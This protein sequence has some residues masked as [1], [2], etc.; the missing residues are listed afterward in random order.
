MKKKL[1]ILMAIVMTLAV[2]APFGTANLMAAGAPGLATGVSFFDFGQTN[3]NRTRGINAAFGANTVFVDRSLTGIPFG[4]MHN[5]VNVWQGNNDART[6]LQMQRALEGVAADMRV[7]LI[8]HIPTALPAIRDFA[9][10]VTGAQFVYAQNALVNS[11]GTAITTGGAGAGAANFNTDLFT[12]GDLGPARLG[13]NTG[14]RFGTITPTAAYFEAAAFNNLQTRVSLGAAQRIGYTMTIQNANTVSVSLGNNE[15]G[16]AVAENAYIVIPVVLRPTGTDT[17]RISWGGGNVSFDALTINNAAA[18]ILAGTNVSDVTLASAGRGHIVLPDLIVNE[19]APNALQNGWAFITPP[20]G[21]NLNSANAAI[22][23]NRANSWVFRFGASN[24]V[25]AQ[26]SFTFRDA[27]NPDPAAPRT[28]FAFQFS[29][30]TAPRLGIGSF[31]ISGLVLEPITAHDWAWGEGGNLSLLIGSWAAVTH[32]DR[33]DRRVVADSVFTVVSGVNQPWTGAAGALDPTGQT[34]PVPMVSGQPAA[35]GVVWAAINDMATATF[36]FPELTNTPGNTLNSTIVLMSTAIANAI[37][38]IRTQLT[39]DVD[40]ATADHQININGLS[41]ALWTAYRNLLVANHAGLTDLIAAVNALIAE[42]NTAPT[43]VVRFALAEALGS[44]RVETNVFGI[45][46]RDIF[47]FLFDQDMYTRNVSIW[48]EPVFNL[49]GNVG[50]IG[51]GSAGIS[52]QLVNVATFTGIG[53]MNYTAAAAANVWSGRLA[54]NA[55]LVTL[56]AT[57]ANL[58]LLHM[59][60]EFTLVDASGNTI[61]DRVRLQEI[62]IPDAA[63]NTRGIVTTVGTNNQ[64]PHN[65]T[66]GFDRAST[67]NFFFGG[68]AVGFT[69]TNVWAAANGAVPRLHFRPV[70][71]AHPDFEGDVFLRATASTA[72]GI[73]TETVHIATFHRPFVIETETTNVRI[74]Y[75]AFAVANITVTENIGAFAGATNTAIFQTNDVLQFGIGVGGRLSSSNSHNHIPFNQINMNNVTASDN[76][77][78]VSTSTPNGVIRVT[79]ERRTGTAAA[80]ASITLH[81]LTVNVDRTIPFGMYDLIVS[82]ETAGNRIANN[83]LAPNAAIMG[84][85][86]R[87]PVDGFRS[88]IPYIALVTPGESVGRVRDV[89]FTLGADHA[90]VDGQR[91]LYSTAIH[92]HQTMGVPELRDNRTW[93]PIRL[94]AYL[95][96]LD[97][98]TNVIWNQNLQT[99]VIRTPNGSVA[100]FQIGRSY[101]VLDG[102]RYDIWTEVPT[103]VYDENF[104]W[105][106]RLIQVPVAPYIDAVTGR[107]MVPIRF[108]ADALGALVHWDAETGT[109]TFN[110][111]D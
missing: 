9:I 12:G 37:E 26:R 48:D 42:L 100:E 44:R 34:R 110:Y 25:T 80:A 77:R 23:F 33:G 58:W 72:S 50:N 57:A 52:T 98:Q 97:M 17:I 10:T 59:D 11:A 78:I 96:G 105:M 18:E 87:F 65:R 111:R 63:A 35:N 45:G 31:S 20:P 7:N 13:D 83:F 3:S 8:I 32:A 6:T 54:Q 24:A 89:S 21:F 70:L 69:L 64:I 36:A 101:Y 22:N 99:V 51:T 27:H 56:E 76:L 67:P 1:A 60:T 2:L 4:A 53:A 92:N 29:G 79:L 107:T 66:W 82:W 28:G 104:G 85:T 108:V 38:D 103:Q 15:A 102:I 41:V 5:S 39:I 109:A 106:D 88:S 94:V 84:Q 40:A 95:F 75:Q 71:S 61:N 49:T 55:A 90:W 62:F 14:N 74:G 47:N 73:F 81:G 19:N 91:V 30:L 46:V 93:V 43:A 16:V 86:P 68:D